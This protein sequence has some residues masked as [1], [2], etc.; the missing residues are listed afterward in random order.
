M[1]PASCCIRCSSCRAGCAF[2][3]A[4]SLACAPS[5]AADRQQS[6]SRVRVV[7]GMVAAPWIEARV[8]ARGEVA[9][10]CA[11]HSAPT[12]RLA[13]SSGAASLANPAAHRRF[14]QCNPSGCHA[15]LF[16]PRQSLP[17]AGS[18]VPG[19]LPS[20]A[21]LLPPAALIL[22]THISGGPLHLSCML[23]Q[24]LVRS[25]MGKAFAGW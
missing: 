11:A 18:G 3:S 1:G 13:R 2:G 4:G 14:K 22:C 25:R 10:R 6:P 23:H 20:P 19:K 15:Q 16:Q 17:A 8:Q 9:A 5:R 12:S 21:A 24:L 7:R